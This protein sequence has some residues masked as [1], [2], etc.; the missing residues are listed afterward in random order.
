M[1]LDVIDKLSG[2]MTLTLDAGEEK[3][4]VLLSPGDVTLQ[5][6]QRRDS[7]FRLHLIQLGDADS[8]VSVTVRQTEEGCQTHLYGLA[9]TRADQRVETETHIR[10]ERGHGASQQLFKN[11]LADR[12]RIAFY[13]ELFIAPDAQKTEALQTNRNI[14]L[15]PEAKVRTRPQLEIYADDVKASHG[16]TTGQ[17]DPN[18][19]FYMQQ[20]GIPFPQ[21][22][23]LLLEAFLEEVLQTL[24]D[25]QL[26]HNV[27]HHINKRLH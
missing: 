18:A 7:T 23:Q 1:R 13:G 12:S 2:P 15:S 17:L 21:A 19:L 8:H 5:V 26:Q 25:E 9:L 14:L 6:N 22:Q 10:H 27:R 11:V 24:P 3:H 20:R 16:A 4:L